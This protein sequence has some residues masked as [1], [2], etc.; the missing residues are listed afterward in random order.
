MSLRQTVC[1]GTYAALLGLISRLALAQDSLETTLALDPILVES[2]VTSVANGLG[3]SGGTVIR[4]PQAQSARVGIGTSIQRHD[5]HR[6]RQQW[7]W[8]GCGGTV[9]LQPWPWPVLFTGG[10]RCNI[11][12]ELQ[13]WRRA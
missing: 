5:K 4:D 3:G 6:R 2:T 12:R 1:V 8:T 11:G 10:S 9:H 7:R 13:K